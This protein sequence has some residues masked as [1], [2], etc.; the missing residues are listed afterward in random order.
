MENK[1]QSEIIKCEVLEYTVNR[2][3]IVKVKQ[4]SNRKGKWVLNPKYEDNKYFVDRALPHVVLSKKE[5][6]I[7]LKQ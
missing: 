2:G 5:Y 7:D 3:R 1:K 6:T 4:Y